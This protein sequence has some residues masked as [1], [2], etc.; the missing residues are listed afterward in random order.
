ML[1]VKLMVIGIYDSVIHSIHIH[2]IVESLSVSV[3]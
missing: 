3:D 1:I 2:F